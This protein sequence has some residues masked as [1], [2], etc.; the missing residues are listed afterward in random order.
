MKA[1]EV[2]SGAAL[3]A[4]YAYP[5]NELG[6]CGPPGVTAT[7]QQLSGAPSPEQAR[8]WARSFDGAWPYLTEIAAAFGSADPLR[9]DVVEAYW[10]GTP[11]LKEIDPGRLLSRLQDSFRGQV[12]N[13]LA[14][15][16]S[17]CAHHSFHVFVVYPW[18]RMLDKGPA[19]LSVLQNCRIRWGKVTD[20]SDEEVTVL[21]R[22]LEYNGALSL[23]APTAETARWRVAGQ[24]L[25][26]RPMAGESVALHW[27][28]ICDRLEPGQTAQLQTYTEMTLQWVNELLGRHG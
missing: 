17:A 2:A 10:V 18:A 6:Y 7:V 22:P 23:G 19:A 12:G 5:P 27:D 3:F 28:W 11:L 21:S 1:A 8:M 16:R 26:G 20:V 13:L 14:S 25:A 24:Q 15:A 9:A 4:R